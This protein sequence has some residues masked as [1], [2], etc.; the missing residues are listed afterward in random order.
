MI[1]EPVVAMVRTSP[2]TIRADY[3]RLLSL[4]L[5]A[6]TP[7]STALLVAVI[8]RRYPF[9]AESTP[10]WQLDGVARALQA[11]QYGQLRLHRTQDD[12]NDWHALQPVARDLALAP[13]ASYDHSDMAVLLTTLRRGQTGLATGA[14][15]LALK[16]A[17]YRSTLAIIDGTTVGNGPPNQSSHPEI[18]N[19]LIASY[20]PVAADAIAATLLGLDPLQDIPHLRVAHEHGIGIAHPGQ[21]SVCG[22]IE[23]AALRWYAHQVPAR[24]V[25][26]TLADF[27]QTIMQSF[28]QAGR[29]IGRPSDPVDRWTAGERERYISWLYD[30]AWGQLF[31]VYHHEPK[32]IADG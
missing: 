16:F 8:E 13:A 9:P 31:A 20:D 1:I 32:L 17:R 19:I 18:G 26:D 30:T 21:I 27:P 3:D 25:L 10:P 22:D 11:R 12:P 2:D 7:E 15:G 24:T 6:F 23:L 28:Q 14:T 4:L 5:P 29:R